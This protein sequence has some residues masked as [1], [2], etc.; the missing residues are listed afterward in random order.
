[1]TAVQHISAAD[2]RAQPQDSARSRFRRT[3]KAH[4]TFEGITFDSQRECSRYAELRKRER[5]GMIFDLERQPAFDVAIN[6][7]HYCRYTADFSYALTP[8]GTK[9]YEDTKSSGTAKDAA[10]RLRRKA[11]ELFHGVTIVEVGT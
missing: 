5:L 6:G 4:R 1:M 10:Y 11:T 3:P 7:Q 9:I 2:Y 8:G